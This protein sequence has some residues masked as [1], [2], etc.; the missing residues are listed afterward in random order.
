MVIGGNKLKHFIQEFKE[1]DLDNV[2][3]VLVTS[4]RTSFES[5]LSKEIIN[6]YTNISN[7]KKAITK[8][9]DE[10]NVRI[11]VC[12]NENKI[13][14]TVFYN[15]KMEKNETKKGIILSLHVL[16]EYKNKGIGTALINSAISVLEKEDISEIELWVFEKN[17]Q[18][19]NF[20]KNRGFNYGGDKRLFC[21]DIIECKYIIN[22]IK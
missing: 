22:V 11:L 5:F 7:C 20:Y 3:Q 4:W 9:Y 2:V 1:N 10:N 12:K 21:D 6:K 8:S 18:A 17:L 14:G 15:F 19:I 16:P 13:L